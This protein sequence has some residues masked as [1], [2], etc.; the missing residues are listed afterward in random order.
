MRL[1]RYAIV[2]A[3][4]AMVF[5]PT[6]SVAKGKMMPKVYMYGFSA[7]FNDSIV[8][9]TD[10]MPVD[11][12]WL[13]TKTDFLLGRENYSLQL[14]NYLSDKMSMPNR[15]C[16]V[17]FGKKMG[18]VKDELSKMREQYTSKAKNK[19][20]VRN[21]ASADFAFRPVDMSSYNEDESEP[22]KEKPKKEKKGNR[23]D[24][25][26]MKPGNGQMPPEGGQMP[27]MR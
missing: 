10:V 27:P 2:L 13:D 23:P 22:K 25:K 3:I 21:I 9:F 26:G 17:V 16:I 7:S 12:A 1:L 8:Y 24:M 4:A 14:K 15:T 18:K 20:D 19:Y 6:K 11:S 5:A